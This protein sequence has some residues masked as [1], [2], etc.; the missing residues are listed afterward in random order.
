[1]A[2]YTEIAAETDIKLQFH[3]NE[4]F[5]V[6]SPCYSVDLENE[7]LKKNLLPHHLRNLGGKFFSITGWDASNVVALLSRIVNQ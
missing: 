6:T 3:A 5:F 4:D 7:E 2:T 1:M